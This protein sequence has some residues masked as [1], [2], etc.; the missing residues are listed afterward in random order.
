MPKGRPCRS[1]SSNSQLLIDHFQDK[2]K[3]RRKVLLPIGLSLDIA[4]PIPSFHTILS[5]WAG[6]SWTTECLR[7]YDASPLAWL[8]A[9]LC[10]AFDISLFRWP[11]KQTTGRDF[12]PVNLVAP[13]GKAKGMHGR[14]ET[15]Q[16]STFFFFIGFGC[17]WRVQNVLVWKIGASV[18]LI[19]GCC[20][21]L[22]L[23]DYPCFTADDFRSVFY[24]NE[25][26]QWEK[27]L[28]II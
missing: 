2:E 28:E 8:H 12:D 10:F 25:D 26:R 24:G 15:H 6:Q 18:R 3:L 5:R 27:I 16:F 19:P 9:P 13:V 20:Q 14:T 17:F 7:T 1:S 22:S 4:L 21:L 23:M 11:S